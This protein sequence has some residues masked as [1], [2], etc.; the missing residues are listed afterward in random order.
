MKSGGALKGA[1]GAVPLGELA[2]MR[3]LLLAYAG[4]VTAF[5][6]PRL[7]ALSASSLIKSSPIARSG[8]KLS[9]AP[10]MMPSPDD[11]PEVTVFVRLISA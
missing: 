4:V 7:I 2:D 1:E 6:Q 8:I 11:P 5:V 9:A 10:T 3:A